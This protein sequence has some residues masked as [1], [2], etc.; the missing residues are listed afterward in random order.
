A[1]GRR[2][3]ATAKGHA[4]AIE[5]ALGLTTKAADLTTTTVQGMQA[6]WQREKVTNA[7][8]NRRCNILRKGLR[9]MVRS[10]RLPFV[11]DVPRLKEEKRRGRFITEADAK[12][13]RENLPDYARE[14]FDVALV[15]PNRRGQLSR[16]LRRY[17]DLDRAV[18]EW[19]P[20][21]CKAD[22]PHVVP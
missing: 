12:L 13:I 10:R 8:I 7:T 16:T 21:E 4:K 22:E 1:N 20:A 17:V 15:L 2:S 11:P 3:L 18:I 6:R 5:T 14:V 9:L 19:P